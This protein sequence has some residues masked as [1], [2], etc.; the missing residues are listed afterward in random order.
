M[1]RRVRTVSAV[2][3]VL[4]GLAC[5]VYAVV[6]WHQME[7]EAPP[8]VRGD[9]AEK[10]SLPAENRADGD[11][12]GTPAAAPTRTDS[13]APHK[14]EAYKRA[15]GLWVVAALPLVFV[16]LVVIIMV[17][18]WLRP[19]PMP[20]TGASDTTDLWQEAGKRLKL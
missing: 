12:S 7:S 11:A 20:R 4:I 8:P 17:Q 6:S 9:G 5:V 13:R 2:L 14:T 19:E 10:Q 1:D 3:L 18:R 15:V 16:A